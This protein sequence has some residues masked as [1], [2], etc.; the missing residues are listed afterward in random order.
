MAIDPL[1]RDRSGE[2]SQKHG[3]TLIR[4]LRTTYGPTFAKGC[5]GDQKLSD[6]L[7]NLD[8]PSLSKLVRDYK[9]G[10]LLIK[11]KTSPG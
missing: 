5:H 2:I 3:N 11:L 10:L 7:G 9:A 6:V 8:G 1:H 4:T